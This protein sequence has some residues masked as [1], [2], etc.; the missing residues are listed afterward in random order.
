[1]FTVCRGKE[2]DVFFIL[3]SSR[4][5][6]DSDWQ[7]MK[8][9]VEGMAWG[10]D[11]T[12]YNTHVGVITYANKADVPFG[13]NRYY[14]RADAAKAISELSRMTGRGADTADALETM[15][16]Y[17]QSNYG[18]RE[19]AVK[20]GIVVTAGQSDKPAVTKEEARKSRDDLGFVLFAVGVGEFDFDEL[21]GI[22]DIPHSETRLF[23]AFEMNGLSNHERAIVTTACKGW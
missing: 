12:R 19:S 22:V 2:L 6:S 13:L 7:T 4:S 9:F 1:L 18:G 15:R 3:D 14:T 23:T 5:V 20:V 8:E 16:K 21:E 17:S 11:I 10:M